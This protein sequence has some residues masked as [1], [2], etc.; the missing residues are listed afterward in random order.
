MHPDFVSEYLQS[1]GFWF[2]YWMLRKE[3]GYS[4]ASALWL[5]WVSWNLLQ[6]RIATDQ[7]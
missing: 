4:R 5:I 2:T 6:H 3:R 1:H 7:I